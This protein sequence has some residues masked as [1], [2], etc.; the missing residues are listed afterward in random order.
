[1]IPRYPRPSGFTLVEL[2][3][4]IGIIAVLVA[5]LL[6]ALNKARESART[7]QGLSN[8]KQL[9]IATRMYAGDSNDWLP[10]GDNPTHWGVPWPHALAHYL[11]MPNKTT[12]QINANPPKVLRCPD[13][14]VPDRGV[15]HYSANPILIPDLNRGIPTP[16][17]ATCLRPYK[18]SRAR[19]PTELM[20]YFDGQQIEAKTYTPYYSAWQINN[21]LYNQTA[22][23]VY[24]ENWF[25]GTRTNT[26]LS[27]GSTMNKDHYG[28]TNFGTAEIRYRHLRDT[29][30]NVVFVDGHAETMK[31]GT[32]RQSNLRPSIFNNMRQARPTDT[33]PN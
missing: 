5:I 8:L 12:A 28:S 29:A 25:T 30:A 21:G 17:A 2:L 1:M 13:A 27:Y 3:V 16:G 15:T 9:A 24:R 33:E 10:A 26:V 32:I 4:V 7:L 6:P 31:K 11:G 20:L 22:S 14:A 18:L 23:L 19:P